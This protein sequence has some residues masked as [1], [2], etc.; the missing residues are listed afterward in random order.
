[1][2]NLVLTS[3]SRVS[4]LEQET[5][6]SKESQRKAIREWCYKREYNILNEYSDTETASGKKERE[7]FD[8]AL[9]EVLTN[10]MVNGL[11]VYDIDRFFRNTEYGLGA[12]RKILDAGKS[13]LVVKQ[14]VNT[15]TPVGKLMFTVFLAVAEYEL[16]QILERTKRGKDNLDPKFF[17]GGTVPYGYDKVEDPLTNGKRRVLVPNLPEQQTISEA[18]HLHSKAGGNLSLSKV[19]EVFTSRQIPGKD[20]N[21]RQW[22]G[23][24]IHKLLS[25]KYREV[26]YGNLVIGVKD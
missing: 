12:L 10:P 21:P 16:S 15:S 22:R 25:N 9:N 17:K 26:K 13:F 2:T 20:G 5:N 11:V 23:V 14:E 8:K 1:M 4:T 18:R 7:G 19:A 24:D 3:Y 6:T